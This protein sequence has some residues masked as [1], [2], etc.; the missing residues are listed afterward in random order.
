MDIDI[1][2]WSFLM[3][4][5]LHN[6]E[7]IITIERWFTHTYPRIKERIPL[8]AQKEIGNRK[9]TTATQ[10]AVAVM[11]V[12]IVACLIIVLT[13]A[14][15]H[16]FLFLGFNM[17]FAL[18][19]FTH[20][21]QSVLLRCYTPG[22]Y[23]SLFLIIPYNLFLFPNLYKSGMLTAPSLAAGFGVMLLCIPLFLLGHKLAEKWKD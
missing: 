12:S 15:Q 20:P 14:S 19:M 6:L 4:F 3:I 9:S 21:L 10:F 1:W 18:N 17:F 5:M 7:E 11:A 23:T 22:V 2:I 13:A 8:F 16:Y